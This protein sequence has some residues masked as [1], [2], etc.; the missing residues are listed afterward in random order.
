MYRC[1]GTLLHNS[2]DGNMQKVYVVRLA[3]EER[4]QLEELVK[5]GNLE[6]GRRPSEL[7]LRKCEI[8]IFPELA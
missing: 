3:N 1:S 4:E 2:K 5:R 6:K 7:K 8:S